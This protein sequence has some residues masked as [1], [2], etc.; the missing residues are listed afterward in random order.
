MHDPET[1][2]V[3]QS[4]ELW[5]RWPKTAGLNLHEL[6]VSTDQVNHEPVLCRRRTP[7]RDPPEGCRRAMVSRAGEVARRDGFDT[8]VIALGDELDVE[9]LD[10]TRSA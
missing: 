2:P 3:K 10:H 5:P 6:P 9:D 4:V 7:V 8:A 1:V